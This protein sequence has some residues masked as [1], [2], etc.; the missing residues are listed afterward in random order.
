MFQKLAHIN[1][2][3]GFWGGLLL[4]GLGLE[5]GAL[6]YQ[7]VL[8]YAPCVLCVQVRAWVMGL[9]LV[10]LLGLWLRHSRIGL[11]LANLLGLAGSL[12]LLER[13]YQTLGTEMGF[14]EGTCSLTAGFPAFLPL[15]VWWPAVFKPLESCGYTPWIIPDLLSMAEALIVISVALVLLF[16]LMLPASLVA[17]TGQQGK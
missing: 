2:S 13:S 8:D 5:L 3:A 17:A 7:Y 6:F 9:L 14:V 1:R 12:G 16:V 11:I 4:L 15:N 10:G